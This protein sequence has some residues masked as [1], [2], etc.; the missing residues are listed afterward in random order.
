LDDDGRS[1]K[2]QEALH[3]SL[4]FLAIGVASPNLLDLDDGSYLLEG[5]LCKDMDSLAVRI[6]A[7]Q[8]SRIE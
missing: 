3:V 8:S 7:G 6:A 4:I 1:L 5:A 2:L